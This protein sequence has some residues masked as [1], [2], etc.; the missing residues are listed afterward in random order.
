MILKF[1]YDKLNFR[2]VNQKLVEGN[3][4]EK[5]FYWDCSCAAE[6]FEKHPELT[7]AEPWWK[8]VK[9]HEVETSGRLENPLM[10]LSSKTTTEIPENLNSF[11]H[12]VDGYCPVFCE[13]RFYS[14]L[15]FMFVAGLIGASSRL[16]NVILSLRTIDKRDKVLLTVKFGYIW[17][18]YKAECFRLWANANLN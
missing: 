15:A 1:V 12:A 7:I 6:N 2:L 18:V 3:V 13:S 10:N 17:S 14:L 4:K 5:K 9:S 16:P 11:S 8:V